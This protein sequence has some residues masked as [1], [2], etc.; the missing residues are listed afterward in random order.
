VQSLC[1][2]VVNFLATESEVQVR[3][4]VLPGEKQWVWNR[5]HSASWVQLKSCTSLRNWDYGHRRSTT[6]TIQDPSIRKSWQGREGFGGGDCQMSDHH[7]LQVY[8]LR[9]E[10]FVRLYC[11]SRYSVCSCQVLSHAYWLLGSK[12][13]KVVRKNLPF[14]GFKLF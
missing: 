5:V 12:H 11:Q 10:G 7:R 2:L 1:G 13:P 6:L 3:F 4:L 14:Y 9:S 8:P